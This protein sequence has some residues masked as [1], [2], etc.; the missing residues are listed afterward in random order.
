MT[1]FNASE[2][3]DLFV[4]SAGAAA[5]LAGLVFVAVSIN[6]D[7]ILEF[8]GLPERALETLILL[9][10]AVVISLF[11]LAPGQG[12]TALGLELAFAGAV[13]VAATGVLT[14]R[15]LPHGGPRAWLIGRAS[16]ATLGTVPFVVAGVSL[17]AERGGGLYWA[18]GGLTFAIVGGVATAWV[19]LIEIRR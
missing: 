9:L 7:H 4:A 19:L 15:S 14:F 3:S 2:W 13:G 18:L 16:I 8:E 11:G 12:S 10:G 5:A 1:A 17:I 6:I